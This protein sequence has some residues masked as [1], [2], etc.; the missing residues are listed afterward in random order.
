MVGMEI[1]DRLALPALQQIDEIVEIMKASHGPY[2]GRGLTSSRS[3]RNSLVLSWST[4][5]SQ[6]RGP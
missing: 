3:G 2:N 5:S 1:P 6:G 4:P